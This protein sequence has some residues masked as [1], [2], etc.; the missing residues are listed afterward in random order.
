MTYDINKKDGDVDRKAE[1]TQDVA[2]MCHA[3][4]DVVLK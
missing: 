1:I 3:T 4:F 2:D